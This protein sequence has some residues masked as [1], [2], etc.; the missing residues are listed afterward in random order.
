MSSSISGI[1]SFNEMTAILPAA[2]GSSSSNRQV[3][4]KGPTENYVAVRNYWR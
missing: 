4:A 1:I 2:K 3:D